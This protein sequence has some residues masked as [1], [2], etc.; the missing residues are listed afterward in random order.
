M[1]KISEVYVPAAKA[2]GSL[3]KRKTENLTYEQKICLDFLKKHIKISDKKAEEM[4]NELQK[5]GRVDA[6]QASMIVNNLP[7]T[8]DDVNLIFSKERTALKDD[9]IKK[10]IEIVNKYV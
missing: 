7:T 10:I 4:M 2:L 5:V 8:K 3:K 9:E 6:R 1:K